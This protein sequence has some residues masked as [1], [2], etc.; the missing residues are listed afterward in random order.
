MSTLYRD[1]DE[2][3]KLD[4]KKMTYAEYLKWYARARDLQAHFSL[5]IIPVDMFQGAF[6][7]SPK[8]ANRPVHQ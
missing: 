7:D 8:G 1:L 3:L 6:A 2:F 4:P 5:P